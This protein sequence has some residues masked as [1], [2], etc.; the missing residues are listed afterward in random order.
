MFLCF[1]LNLILVLS[2][3]MQ[4]A[5]CWEAPTPFEIFSADGSRVFVFDPTENG[6]GNAFAAVYE[7][8]N[9]ERKLFYTIDELSSFAYEGNFHFSND[10]TH[11]VRTFPAPGIPAFEVFSNGI[12]TRT[13][14]RSDFI[15]NYSD[16][17]AAPVTSIGP[18]Y[19]INWRFEEKVLD[20]DIIV[21]STDEGNTFLFDL[22][23]ARFNTEDNL[24]FEND[25]EVQAEDDFIPIPKKQSASKKI[26]FI[27]VGLTIFLFV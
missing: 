3:T 1:C 25:F 8:L 20:N 4:I 26:I 22:T 10:M 7:I 6:A 23:T 16:D 2:N 15:E 5:A 13:V 17:G 11:F 12:R 14:L 24:V 9:N 18:T 27:V 19:K 21:I